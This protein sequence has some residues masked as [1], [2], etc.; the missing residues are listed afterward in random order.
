M[1]IV[2]RDYQKEIIDSVRS[3]MTRGRKSILVCSPTGSGKTALTAEMLYQS[4]LKGYRSF[5]NVHRRELVMQSLMAFDKIGVPAG[6]I[7]NGFPEDPRHH[8]QITSIQSLARRLNKQKPPQLIVWDECHHI[9][10]GTWESIYNHFDK[11]FHVGL[12]ATPERLDGKGLSKFFS[13]MVKGPSVSSLIEDKYLCDYKLFAPSNVD[14][15][16]VRKSMGDFNKTQLNDLMDKPTIT[17]NSI[18]E[19]K[20]QAMGKRAVVFCVSVKHSE[21]VVDEFNRSNIP[22]VHVDGKSHPQDRDQALKDFA[23]GK[24]KVLSNVDLFGEGFDL[25]SIECAILL[26]P[27]S[28]LSLYL[29]QVGRALRP[30]PGK[31]RAIILDHVGNVQRHG[32]PD[33]ERNWHLEGKAWRLKGE[34]QE[35]A[36]TKICERCFAAQPP[37]TLHCKYCKHIFEKK[38]REVAEVEGDLEEV[39]VKLLRRKKLMAQA[40]AE[41][42]EELYELGVE[43]GYKHA[44]RWAQHI[45][46]SRQRK[47]HKGGRRG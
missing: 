11:S 24:I 17:G 30:S 12:T 16:G 14:L 4:S 9:A 13:V 29:Q 20:K 18:R 42:L 22:A 5:F 35:V 34:D 3:H 6:V 33:Q 19:Y 39:D 45:Y 2:L 7:A 43:R 23:S 15:K 28:S 1:P 26:R 38:P 46:Q 41:S 37:G 25:P 44:R 47:K 10:A 40:Q 36:T 8:V 32:L 21:H 31:E 27:T